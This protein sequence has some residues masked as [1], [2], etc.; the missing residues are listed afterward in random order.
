MWLDLY[1][2]TYT[3]YG[4]TI[5]WL[6]VDGDGDLPSSLGQL[7][8]SCSAHG[9][10]RWTCYVVRKYLLLQVTRL[11]TTKRAAATICREDSVMLLQ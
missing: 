2:T 3:A 5:P 9:V 7:H 6:G 11:L 8:A 1:Q 10:Y 4:E